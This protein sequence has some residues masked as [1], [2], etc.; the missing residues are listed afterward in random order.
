MVKG[1]RIFTAGKSLASTGGHGDPTNGHKMEFMG[2][3]GPKDGVVN[4]P[5]DGRKAVR[6]RYKEGAD[7]IKITAT[8]GV[9]SVAKSGHNP[10]FTIEEIKAIT[11]TAEDY[12]MLTAAHAHGDLGMQRAI[13][14][15]I[16][17]IEHGSFMS[18]KTMEMMKEYNVYMVPTISAGKKVVEKAKI[19]GYFPEVVA[20]KAIE[21]GALVQETFG[22]AYK[23][24]VPIAFGTD[25]A[26]FPHGENA[27]EFGYM[28][29]AGMP[30]MEAI[31]AATVTNAM[32]LGIGDQLGQISVGYMADIIAVK[33]D[34]VSDVST[35]EDVGFVMKEGVIYKQ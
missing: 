24:G 29:E 28:V 25:A 26:V 14:G 16:K 22:K 13:L 2:D 31:Q 10:Q 3:P 11:E 21:V 7:V 19:P 4:S 15:G 9:L 5:E 1:P 35:L 20:R 18:E 6:Q 8:G 23:K 32:L 12:G 30:P 17:T 27:I 34:P 33:G